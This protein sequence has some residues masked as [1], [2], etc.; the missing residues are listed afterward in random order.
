MDSTLLLEY[1]TTSKAKCKKCKYTLE[2]DKLRV[3]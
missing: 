2:K 1:A 3:K